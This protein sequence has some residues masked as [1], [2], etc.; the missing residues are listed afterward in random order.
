MK[1]LIY[2]II[3]T[4]TAIAF[5]FAISGVASAEAP[6]GCFGVLRGA[7]GSVEF[8]KHRESTWQPATHD[9]CLF[10]DYGLRTGERSGAL[11]VL[12]DMSEIRLNENTTIFFTG[13]KVRFLL[14]RLTGISL[15]SGELFMDI[16]EGYDD[17]F[18]QNEAGSAIVGGANADIMLLREDESVKDSPYGMSVFVS[19]GAVDVFDMFLKYRVTVGPGEQTNVSRK[20]PPQEVY[21]Y[22]AKV[23]NAYIKVWRDALQPARFIDKL[24]EGDKLSETRDKALSCPADFYKAALWCCPASCKSGPSALPQD[25]FCPDGTYYVG[26]RVCCDNECLR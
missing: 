14:T 24:Y 17:I 18:V 25:I 5:S 12:D 19:G 1:T 23:F 26:N 8:V 16:T 3:F 11:V 21:F 2:T 10:E 15:L 22:N 4:L 6:S 7:A 20:K 13:T 9:M